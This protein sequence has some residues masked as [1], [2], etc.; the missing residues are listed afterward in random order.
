MT[1][2]RKR[3]LQRS[4]I[5]SVG[6]P[7]ASTLITCSPVVLAQQAG[8]L[9]EVVVTAQKRT[10][11]LQDV[12]LSVTALGTETLEAHNVDS[13]TDYVKLLPS[14]SYQSF[15]PGFALVYMRGVAS[16]ENGNHSG[17]LPSV[18]IYLDEQPI[19]TIQ[20]A[21]DLHIYDIARVEALAGP[22]GTL[23][24]A[25]SQSGTLRI[26]T[27]KPDP[28]GFSAA[29]DVQG[30]IIDGGDPGAGVEGYANIPI[31]SQ[32]AIRLVGWYQ[33]D[34]GYIDNIKGTRTYP[35]S[36]A[37]I[38][39]TVT[40]TAEKNYNDV[41]TY[42]GRAALKFD[43]NDN[44]TITPTLMGQVQK[45]NGNFAYDRNLG[46]LKIQH[47]FPESTKDQWYQAALTIEGHISNLDVVYAGAYLNRH[48]N[49]R[50]DYTD[51]AY[52]YDVLY[53]Y[54]AYFYDNGGNLIDPSQ[55]IIG[56]DR[57]KKT[58]HEIRISTPKE[59]PLRAVIGGFVQ[60]QQ[61]NIE[62]RYLVDNLTDFFDVT[63]WPDT[64]WLTEQ[65]RVDRDYAAFGEIALDLTDQWTL[66]GGFRYYQARNSL[67]GFF[68]YNSNF[69]SRT[70]EAACFSTYQLR[71]APC[72]NLDKEVSEEGVTPKVN[73]TWQYNEDIMLYA[74]WSEGFRPGGINRR[75]TLPPYQSDFL[76]NYEF[77]WKTSLLNNT[78]RFNGAVFLA[79]WDDIQ[80]SYLGQN[81]LT[82]IKNAN[83]AQVKGI[84]VSVDWVPTDQ[85]TI[86]G[87]FSYINAELTQNYC[88][89]VN[90][91]GTPVTDCAAPLAP[92]GT[93][94]PITPDFK[95]NIT[96][97][98][99]FVMNNFDSFIQGSLVGQTSSWA[100]LRSSDRAT[101]GK[102]PG[103]VTLDFL[104]GI[105]RDNYSLSL[106]LDN[107]T[108]ERAQTYVYTECSVS[109]CGAE[110]YVVPNQ[111]RT[112]GIRF[113]Q[114]F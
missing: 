38:D 20:G 80:F 82:E 26:I 44:W 96:A 85:W 24:G 30:N 114:K 98:Y 57:F 113:G 89:T 41:D 105:S 34:G 50:L 100:D 45:A 11:N 55:Y 64:I 52:F 70:G 111:P 54:G 92:E 18:G 72:T 15:G 77:G 37:T 60:R 78:L 101:I 87:G 107:A 31:N 65:K 43:L 86:G 14:V 33:H 62:Q 94:L 46:D 1:R 74:T 6:V 110:P 49:E 95:G 25:S 47:Y 91:D 35:T 58:S 88:G 112:F 8:V 48:E 63:G 19:T 28:S 27:N 93:S 61:H 10:E 21:L 53:G 103:Y 67:F 16:G 73:L 12:P 5:A 102:Q 22:Q 97:R 51:Y 9:E 4:R 104:A 17:P 40:G 81:G 69:S 66:T 39:N 109:I 75:G 99:S 59:L 106:F 29:Y 32:A 3:K 90:P 84:E 108:D 76:T 42:G 23:Y 13:F 56:K 7:L 71:N 79:D 2:S 36:G 83:A 68:G